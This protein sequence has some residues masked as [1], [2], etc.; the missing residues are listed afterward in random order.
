[1]HICPEMLAGFKVPRIPCEIYGGI[2]TAL[3]IV[4]N[5]NVV[6]VEQE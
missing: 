6:E 4:N 2:F 5:I 3:L 1:M